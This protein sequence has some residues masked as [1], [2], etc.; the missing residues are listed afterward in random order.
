MDNKRRSIFNMSIKYYLYNFEGEQ[1]MFNIWEFDKAGCRY[2]CAF[3]T[4][5]HLKSYNEWQYDSGLM[6]FH[7]INYIELTKAEV[8]LKCL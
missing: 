4:K 8:F 6:Q 1:D 3:T 5:D 7:S 2:R